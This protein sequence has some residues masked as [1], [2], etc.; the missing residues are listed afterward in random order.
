[1]KNDNHAFVK[2]MFIATMAM[3][4]LVGAA[5]FYTVQLRY[6]ISSTA[7]QT[8]L[9]E[10]DLREIERQI[11]ESHAA[12]ERAQD[13][14]ILKLLNQQWKLGLVP[15]EPRQTAYISEDPVMRLASKFNEGLFSEEPEQPVSF[16]V[17]FRR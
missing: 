11:N 7:N 4:G 16:Q 6:Q 8:K 17:A 1:M 3:F 15:P 2:L 5:G 9:C 12:I 14:A 13:P 10:N